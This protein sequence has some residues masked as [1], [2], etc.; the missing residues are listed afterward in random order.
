MGRLIR[1]LANLVGALALLII[2]A[3]AVL[4]MVVDPNDYKDN[5][6]KAVEANTGR[7]LAIE[8]DIGL[9]VFRWLAVKIG[10]TRLPPPGR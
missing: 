2:V 7:N 6:A 10:P 9:P 1:V 5:I 4:P 3:A 8:G